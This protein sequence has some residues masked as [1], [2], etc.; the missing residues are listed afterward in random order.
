MANAG[1]YA[2]I[3]DKSGSLTM[4]YANSKYDKSDEV[5]DKLGYKPGAIKSKNEKSDKSDK[6]DKNEKN[7]R[8]EK[9]DGKE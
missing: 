9:G 5:L 7:N 1:G 2:I 6:T 8:E 3:F 4:I